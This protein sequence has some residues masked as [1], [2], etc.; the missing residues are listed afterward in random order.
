MA[1]NAGDI[2]NISAS[3]AGIMEDVFSTN[4]PIVVPGA[5]ASRGREE[6]ELL[7]V[8]VAQGVVQHLVA[9]PDAFKV[10]VSVPSIG[11]ADGEVIEIQG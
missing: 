7:F 9:N 3:M 6:R 1:L 4:L 11:D 5:D 10:R 2:N 8:A